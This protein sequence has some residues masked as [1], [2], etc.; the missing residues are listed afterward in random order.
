MRGNGLLIAFLYGD[1]GKNTGHKRCSC[2]INLKDDVGVRNFSLYI[3][4]APEF[5]VSMGDK[6]PIPPHPHFPSQEAPPSAFSLILGCAPSLLCRD[7]EG[8]ARTYV[9]L[10]AQHDGS[11]STCRANWFDTFGGRSQSEARPRSTSNF[12]QVALLGRAE[13]TVPP[14][15]GAVALFCVFSVS[16]S[17]NPLGSAIEVFK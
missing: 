9:W 13:I 16:T 14:Q 15:F 11:G 1:L 12:L 17:S 3:S 7:F 2:Y 10:L 6:S 8:Q 5:M 4:K